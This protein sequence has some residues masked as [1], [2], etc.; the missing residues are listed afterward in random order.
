MGCGGF[1]AESMREHVGVV[2]AES[3]GEGLPKDMRHNWWASPALSPEACTHMWM[4]ER[5]E[6]VRLSTS[7]FDLTLLAPHMVRSSHG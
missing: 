3:A 1:K 6:R 5:V 7:S 4:W 2:G